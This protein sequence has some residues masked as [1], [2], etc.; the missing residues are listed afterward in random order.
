M[1][2]Q[3]CEVECVHLSAS[4][5]VGKLVELVVT[6]RLQAALHVGGLCCEVCNA[7]CERLYYLVVGVRGFWCGGVKV[8]SLHL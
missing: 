3:E 7:V 6:A 4:T 1:T 5:R 2:G 8:F